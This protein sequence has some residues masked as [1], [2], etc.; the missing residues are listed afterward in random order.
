MQLYVITYLI[1]SNMSNQIFCYTMYVYK[2][3]STD[4]A[5]PSKKEKCSK[6]NIESLDIYQKDDND[7]SA[8]RL[9]AIY[10]HVIFTSDIWID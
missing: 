3:V 5:I 10:L 2:I 9:A 7:N 8:A 1:G 6:W 4:N